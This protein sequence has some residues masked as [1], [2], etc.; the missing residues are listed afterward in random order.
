M[1]TDALF[2]R[3]I[4]QLK[5]L[6]SIRTPSLIFRDV[7][8]FWSLGCFSRTGVKGWEPM[9]LWNLNQQGEKDLRLRWLLVILETSHDK[10]R[11]V[12]RVRIIF[13]GTC[14]KAT[15]KQRHAILMRYFRKLN[16]CRI[17]SSVPRLSPKKLLGLSLTSH[18]RS[19][20]PPPQLLFAPA[21]VV[22]L[23]AYSTSLPPDVEKPFPPQKKKTRTSY[24]PP[25]SLSKA[26][27]H[28]FDK[29]APSK[30]VHL[31]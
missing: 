24:E 17:F 28:P 31:P 22:R 20:H 14:L 19:F 25:F 8:F 1:Q 23:A 6:G 10:D 4:E 15:W 16:C 18:P 30:W 29:E 13:N 2:Q 11:G 12:A 21:L 27:S 3:Y 9:S 7:F 26:T 5:D